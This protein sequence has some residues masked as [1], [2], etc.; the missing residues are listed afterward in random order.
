MQIKGLDTLARHV[1]ELNSSSGRMKIGATFF[2]VFVFTTLYFITTDQIPTWT[3]DSQIVVT[4][5]G[6]LILSRVFRQKKAFIE[7]HKE[8]AF[9]VAF[10][11]FTVPSLAIFSASIIHVAYMNGPK[12]TL[13]TLTTILTWFGWVCI[14]VGAPLFIR[15][16]AFLGADHAA[17]L[18]VYFPGSELTRS[19][20]YSIVRHPMHAGMLRICIG[21]ACLN[22]GIFALT[23]VI[24]LP[25]LVFGWVRLVEEKELIERNPNYGEYRRQVP[26][27]FPYPKQIFRFFK[28]VL[29]GQSYA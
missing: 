2:V 20:I 1:P 22:R 15:A 14:L 13:P 9:A 16:L 7:K 11:Q 3:L 21:L 10:K 5:L 26:A 17:M 27:F 29:T 4:T 18:Y 12:F 19:S 6:Y 25:L 23:F 8:Q 24:I 28:F